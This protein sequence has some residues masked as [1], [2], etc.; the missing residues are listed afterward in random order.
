MQW[1]VSAR[2]L[3]FPPVLRFGLWSDTVGLSL[4]PRSTVVLLSIIG[5]HPYPRNT[6]FP[7]KDMICEWPKSLNNWPRIYVLRSPLSS[8]S[9]N[10]GRHATTESL[11]SIGGGI[12]FGEGLNIGWNIKM[13]CCII[14][15]LGTWVFFNSR[16]Q[17]QKVSPLQCC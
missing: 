14:L 5:F 13:I 8:F 9:Q 16:S 15:R 11:I 17:L 4:S 10:F 6:C 1:I 2:Q 7:L 3:I 12:F